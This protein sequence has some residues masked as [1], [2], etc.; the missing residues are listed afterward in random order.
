MP[1]TIHA[2]GID[3]L[4]REERI[5]LVLEIWDSIA[6]ES[7]SPLLTESQRD[8][9]AAG[10]PKTRLTLTTWCLGRKSRRELW[11]ESSHEPASGPS[12]SGTGGVGRSR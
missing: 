7:T 1:S 3:Q 10:S 11:P 12:P 2:L 6:A 4:S 5:D 9:L 8:E